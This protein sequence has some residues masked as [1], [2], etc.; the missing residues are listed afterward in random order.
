MHLPEELHPAPERSDPAAPIHFVDCFC[1][2]GGAA[3]G[4]RDAGLD[5]ALGVDSNEKRLDVFSLNFPEAEGVCGHLLSR[6]GEFTIPTYY[7]GFAGAISLGG[8]LLNVRRDVVW[9]QYHTK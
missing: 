1:G 2:L 5:V 4:A 6:P 7:L 3:Q 8:M 9:R